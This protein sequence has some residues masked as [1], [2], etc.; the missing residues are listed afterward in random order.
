MSSSVH[1]AF[2]LK[3]ES[4][5]IID[6]VKMSWAEQSSIFL[7]ILAFKLKN[8]SCANF[9]LL[10][11]SNQWLRR[12][13]SVKVFSRPI[14]NLAWNSTFLGTPG[15]FMLILWHCNCHWQWRWEYTDNKTTQSSNQ[16]LA[17]SYQSK[18]VWW[19]Y[20]RIFPSGSTQIYEISMKNWYLEFSI[21][22][23]LSPRSS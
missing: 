3:Q 22:A 9:F 23:K 8:N 19:Y 13:F 16:C 2:F 7:L 21:F 12:Y 18:L 5:F 10:I 6:F 15:W 14:F 20:L 1:Y 11:R 4:C 17:K